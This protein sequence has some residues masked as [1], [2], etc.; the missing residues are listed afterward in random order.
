MRMLSSYIY[1]FQ[2]RNVRA[3]LSFKFLLM[4]RDSKL[5]RSIRVTEYSVSAG[6]PLMWPVR[7]NV[8]QR[9]T[10]G[11][12]PRARVSPWSV[13]PPFNLRL[14]NIQLKYPSSKSN[15]IPA[16]KFVCL[17]WLLSSELGYVRKIG[18][19]KWWLFAEEVS[20]SWT[21]GCLCHK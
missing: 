8:K 19:G 2:L 20:W 11:L 12:S 15:H 18:F 16:T 17:P 4:V 1:I 3:C 21:F 9:G 13:I 6:L 10:R 5:S 7:A 14:S